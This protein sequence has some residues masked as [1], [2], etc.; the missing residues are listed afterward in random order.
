MLKQ[1]AG[2]VHAVP[3][4]ARREPQ[5]LDVQSSSVRFTSSLAAALLASRLNTL[6]ERIIY[7]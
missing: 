6:L 2:A 5:G 4:S 7:G 1:A 3:Y